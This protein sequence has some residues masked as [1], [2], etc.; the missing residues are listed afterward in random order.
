MHSLCLGSF[1][2]RTDNS[3]LS[4]IELIYDFINGSLEHRTWISIKLIAQRLLEVGSDRFPLTIL[5]LI[6]SIPNIFCLNVTLSWRIITKPIPYWRWIGQTLKDELFI[7][8]QFAF[9]VDAVGPSSSVLSK[10]GWAF[11]CPFRDFRNA[12]RAFWKLLER[13]GLSALWL[14]TFLNLLLQLSSFYRIVCFLYLLIWL[15]F[16]LLLGKNP[17]EQ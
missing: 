5:L 17:A 12:N 8:L 4:K 1:C 7:S 10:T 9:L 13:I 2:W 6:A 16:V 14:F 15:F 11:P 3:H